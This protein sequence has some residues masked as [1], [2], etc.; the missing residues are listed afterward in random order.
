MCL[1]LFAYRLDYQQQAK[2]PLLVAANRDEYHS[3]AAQPAR[4][5]PELPQILAGRDLQGGGTWLGINRNG[6]FAAVTNFREPGV[7]T[8]EHSRG[9]LCIDFL[10]GSQSAAAYT[11]QISDNADRYGGFNL[12]LWDGGQLRYY[13][14]QNHSRQ[15]RA[16]RALEPGIYGMSNGYL[17]EAWPKVV[18]GKRALQQALATPTV[19]AQSL[20]ILADRSQP[21]DQHLPDTGV[22]LGL[23]RL[24]APRFILSEIYGT[25]VST[26]L[27]LSADNNV[28]FVE[29][30]FDAD[31]A[32]S[33]RV[34]FEFSVR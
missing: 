9:E 11:E 33:G 15:D 31:G 16:G 26:V 29:Q 12:L 7:T 30:S 6:R 22:G 20:E 4:F 18:S 24:L 19:M 28:H 1:I 14:N 32:H 34:E 3:R 23:E 21:R 8:G 13:S 2:L 17:D 5:W 10:C 25:R 27:S